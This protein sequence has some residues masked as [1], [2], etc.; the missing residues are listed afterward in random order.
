[1]LSS[2]I[3]QKPQTMGQLDHGVV[4]FG[5]PIALGSDLQLRSPS[6]NEQN[7]KKGCPPM[8]YLGQLDP[9]TPDSKPVVDWW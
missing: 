3:G 6:D 9:F 8:I 4:R 2:R 7:D 1:M 5:H